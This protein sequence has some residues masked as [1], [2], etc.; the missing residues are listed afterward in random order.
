MPFRIVNNPVTTVGN[1]T[2]SAEFCK[3]GVITRSGPVGSFTDTTDT[4]ANLWSNT[5]GV[6]GTSWLCQYLNVSG[7]TATLAGGT[8]VTA[9]ANTSSSLTVTTG[10]MAMILFTLTGGYL[11]TAQVLYQETI[12]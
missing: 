11:V 8:G 2:L 3:Q 1:G 5:G 9:S 4:A 7:Q 10:K 12:T 6:V